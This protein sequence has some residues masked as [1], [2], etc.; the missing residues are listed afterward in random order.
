MISLR[1]VAQE[2]GF[3]SS[4]SAREMAQ[5]KNIAS[6]ISFNKVAASHYIDK[7]YDQVGGILSP[8]GS[9]M[10]EVTGQ[11]TNYLR[12][13]RGGEIQY[14]AAQGAGGIVK[15]LTTIRYVG[16]RCIKR[17]SDQVGAPSNEPFIIVGI[18]PPSRRDQVATLK[19]PNGD[20]VYE[21]IDGGDFRTDPAD[22]WTSKPPEDMVISC[23]VM[24]HDHGDPK[25]IKAAIAKAL[26]E[27]ADAAAAAEG[28][29][30]PEDWVNYITVFIAGAVTDILGMGDD[31]IGTSSFIL[32][33]EDMI[34]HPQMIK[35]PGDDNNEY[36]KEVKI[37]GDGAEYRLYF[38]VFNEEKTRKI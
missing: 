26:K 4:V 33:F 18:Y 19:F 14:S 9:V 12:T 11:T 22:I 13:Y 7:K 5:R 32:K 21:D 36:N 8:L 16:F 37:L 15:N 2:M 3:G 10:T 6:P 29:N 38:Q 34:N 25:R 27:A 28:V 24:E 20:G 1:T 17:A 31:V 30:V 35:F 23:L